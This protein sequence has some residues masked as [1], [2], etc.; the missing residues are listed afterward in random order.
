MKTAYVVNNKRP[1]RTDSDI[2]DTD[3]GVWVFLA[4]GTSQYDKPAMVIDGI[5][6]A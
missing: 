4:F 5:A 6:A 2:P 1:C 3:R